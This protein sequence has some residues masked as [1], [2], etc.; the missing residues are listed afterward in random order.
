MNFRA[1]FFLTGLFILMLLGNTNAQTVVLAS[2]TVKPKVTYRQK[3]IKDSIY[4]A[5][6]DF[7][8]DSIMK[9]TW[10]FPDSLLNKHMI[11]DSII[12][13][14]VYG[15]SNLIN[16]YKDFAAVEKSKY[17]FGKP[18]AKG[19]IWVLLVV[20]VLLVLFGILKVSFG[21]QLQTIIQSFF[22]NR[23]LNNLNKEDNLFTSWPFLLLFIQF[24]FTVGMFF[25]LISQYYHIAFP[26]TGI[27][28]YLTISV[29]IIVLYI[30]KIGV[31]RM[32]G[33][34]FNVQKPV[35]E[36][37]TILYLSYF[38]LS[39]MFIPLV[40][41][42]ALSPIKYAP[43]FIVLSYV[44]L[45]TIF[46]FQLIR[47]GVNI[48]SNNRFSKVYLFLYFCALEICPILILIKAIGL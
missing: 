35:N 25:Y 37:V 46:A 14:N 44:V 29:L 32:I 18:M 31:L 47:A 48:L 2:D 27:Q 36:Y 26:G 40:I 23:V 1:A 9:H 3:Q 34:L 10:L 12:K 20:S 38:N 39:L 6:R 22:S 41:A 30:F 43:F 5:R 11:M 17:R 16:R 19:Q 15:K 4:N 45:G 28:F 13:A 42:F 8:T 24:G 7:V 33:H 21:R